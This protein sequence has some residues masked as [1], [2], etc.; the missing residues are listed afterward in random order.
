M[1]HHAGAGGQRRPR[2]EPLIEMMSLL[3]SRSGAAD[4]QVGGECSGM[5]GPSPE[6]LRPPALVTY[7]YSEHS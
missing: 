1:G 6:A 3:S 7:L 5:A 4:G 2:G